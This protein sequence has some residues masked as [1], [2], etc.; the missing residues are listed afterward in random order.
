MQK[1]QFL[2]LG[3][4]MSYLG[5][6]GSDSE[7]LLSYL[8]S[9]PSNLCYCKVWCKTKNPS[10]WDQKCLILVFLVWILKKYCHI[11]SQRPCIC[12]IAKLCAKMKILKFWPKV[13]DLGIFGL[14]IGNTIVIIETR[15]LEFVW[16]QN[17]GI[18]GLKFEKDITIFE[19]NTLKV[20]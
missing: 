15:T 10:I 6:L 14:D 9:A 4:R 18:Y 20:L 7:K 8:N 3:L 2:N 11:W 16:L 5:V 13:A 17:L 19:I 12:L 1:W